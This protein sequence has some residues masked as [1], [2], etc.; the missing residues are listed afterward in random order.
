MQFSIGDRLNISGQIY[1]VIGKITYR[2]RAD[3]CVWDEYR[4]ISSGGQEK[5]LSVDDAYQEYSLS[6]P[7]GHAPTS[8]Y[9]LVD[10][11]VQVVVKSL[12]D[13]DVDNSETAKFME[14]ED[15]TEEKIMSIEKW[16]DGVEVSQG[17]YLEPHQIQFVEALGLKNPSLKKSAILFGKTGGIVDKIKTIFYVVVFVL[18]GIVGALC[19]DS[20][21]YDAYQITSTAVR[22]YL[23]TSSSFTYVTDIIDGNVKANATDGD[24]MNTATEAKT[25]ITTAN[26]TDSNRAKVFTTEM[27]TD[28]AAK[29]IIDGIEGE[30]EEV[31]QNTDD[32]DTSIAILTKYEYC[33]VYTSTDY[34]TTVQVCP[35][36]YAYSDNYKPYR[37]RVGTNRYYRRFYHSW[38]HSSDSSTYSSIPSAYSNYND[39]DLNTNTTDTYRS[40]SDTVR[41]DSIASRRSSGGGTSYGK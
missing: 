20:D 16:S 21:S 11:G 41:Q 5:W 19:D 14:Y 38:A 30:T 34:V 25:E 40:Y 18:F 12:G 32:G 37:S 29:F 36:E 2:N 15:S 17:Y 31:Q 13:V 24:V 28:M 8:E 3:R 23:A 9:H 26:Q 27:N 6:W 35:R 1:D 7:A 4:L 10:E 33:L 22:D 39:V